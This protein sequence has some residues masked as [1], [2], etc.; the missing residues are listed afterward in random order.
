[1]QKLSFYFNAHRVFVEFPTF[2]STYHSGPVFHEWEKMLTRREDTC[3]ENSSEIT[4]ILFSRRK[5]IPTL[6]KNIKYDKYV[7]F[8]K[9]SEM[10]AIAN[11]C[12]K[13]E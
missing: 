11:T 8:A 3:L 7:K 10:L 4:R 2:L 9:Y 5:F 12:T 13:H 1:M 6:Q